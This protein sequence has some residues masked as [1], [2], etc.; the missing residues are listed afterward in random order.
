MQYSETAMINHCTDVL[1]GFITKDES[2]TGFKEIYENS[3]N[4]EECIENA[5]EICRNILN[6]NVSEWE[7][8]D[9]KETTIFTQGSINSI[10]IGFKKVLPGFNNRCIPREVQTDTEFLQLKLA[11]KTC[12]HQL[13]TVLRMNA[14]TENIGI[15]HFKMLNNLN[16]SWQMFFEDVI[17]I[18]NDVSKELTTLA[19]IN[20]ATIAKHI[21]IDSYREFFQRSHLYTRLSLL[22]DNQNTLIELENNIILDLIKLY[23]NIVFENF[24]VLIDIIAECKNIALSL[25]YIDVEQVCTGVTWYGNSV[26]LDFSLLV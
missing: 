4:P 15:E 5:Y 2:T 14:S 22:S 7:Q 16:M 9:L 13:R 10:F 20:E 17:R 12:I 23:T 26:Y 24:T 6:S 21:Q 19:Q 18:T 11:S 1:L 3:K 25:G 8:N